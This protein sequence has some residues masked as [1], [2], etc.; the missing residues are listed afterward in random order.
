MATPHVTGT[1]A[2]LLSLQGNISPPDMEAKLKAFA[3]NNALTDIRG[4]NVIRIMPRALNNG[5]TA[6][7]TVNALAQRG[8]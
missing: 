5:N 4:C 1:I 3:L 2:Y 6:S 7:G 8:I